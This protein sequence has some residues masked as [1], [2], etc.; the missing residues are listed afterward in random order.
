MTNKVLEKEVEE[1]K[2]GEDSR[3]E[4]DR[5]LIPK[6][7]VKMVAKRSKPSLATLEKTTKFYHFIFGVA[8]AYF[9]D[10][11]SKKKFIKEKGL[12]WRKVIRK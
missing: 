10:V 5:R 3:K 11:L 9:T 4:E 6:P 1:E 2:E 7:R 8:M 12:N